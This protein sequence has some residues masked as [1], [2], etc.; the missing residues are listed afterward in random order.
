MLLYKRRIFLVEDKVENR[1]IMQLLLEQHGA[2][3]GFERW[4]RDTVQRL[5]DFAPVDL[6]LLDLMLPNNVSGYDIFDRIRAFS[7]FAKVPIVAVSAADPGVAVP[8]VR[9]KGF[10]GFIAKPIE[11]EIFPSQIARILNNQP[12]WYTV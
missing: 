1:S 7:D 4:G 6:I 11:F 10:A 8:K 3:V 2:K 9:A 12:V 5:C